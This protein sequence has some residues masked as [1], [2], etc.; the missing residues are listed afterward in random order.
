[1][2]WDTMYEF[3]KSWFI[4]PGLKWDLMLISIGLAI[5]FGAVWMLGYWPYIFKKVW[6]WPVMIVSAFLSLLSVT[7]VQ[8]PLQYY[9]DKGLSLAWEPTTLANWY[10]LA[11]ISAVLASGLVQEA[12]KSVPMAIWWWRSGKNITPKMGL[13]IGAVAGA[14]FGIFEAFWVHS[15]IFSA[16]WTTQLI[17]QYG[18]DGISGFWERFFTV[19]FHTAV[20]AL[21]GYGLAKGKW[22]QYFLIAAGLHS[23][24]NY[25]AVFLT[26]FVYIR[27]VDWIKVTYIEIYIAV[28]TAI[29][30]AVVLYL[31]WRKSKDEEP[32]APAEPIGPL[33][34]ELPAD[35]ND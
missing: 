16:G 30:T 27:P 26:Y 24:A 18:F 28:L 19:G 20:S 32:M 13:L 6:V 12:S 7:F 1:M 11:G 14:G 10:L 8:I 25:S 4:F 23:L 35:I 33:P 3:L 29:I 22:W 2:L 15:R 5:A 9:I 31:R 21:V 34:T 17:G